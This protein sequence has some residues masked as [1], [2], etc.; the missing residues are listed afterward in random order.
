MNKYKLGFYTGKAA[1]ILAIFVLF[2]FAELNYNVLEWS[3]WS[4]LIFVVLSIGLFFNSKPI[5]E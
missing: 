2:C 3:V 1:I 4:R 5:K